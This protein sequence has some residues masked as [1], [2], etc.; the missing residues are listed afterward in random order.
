VAQPRIIE[1]RKRPDV[2]Y[3]LAF[4]VGTVVFS[5]ASLIA[6]FVPTY[7]LFA[8]LPLYSGSPMQLFWANVELNLASTI[9][10]TLL[11]GCGFWVF[12]QGMRRLGV[13]KLTN[14]LVWLGA[15]LAVVWALLVIAVN[16][17][18]TFTGYMN[19]TANA[20]VILELIMFA[21]FGF[22]YVVAWWFVRRRGGIK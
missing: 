21:V 3:V 10:P 8:P 12:S 17:I 4:T 14:R 1:V 7:E 11:F 20:Q 5:V 16:L 18:V 19:M 2:Q 15:V 9:L 13:K 22:A 6:S